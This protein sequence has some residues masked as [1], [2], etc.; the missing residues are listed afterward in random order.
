MHRYDRLI[1]LIGAENHKKLL[2]SSV[3]VV[4]AGGLGSAVLAYLSGS[5][6][7]RIGISDGDLVELHNLDRQFI[8]ANKVG[9]NKA[10]SAKLFVE[11]LNSDVVVEVFGGFEEIPVKKISEYDAVVSCVDSILLRHKINEVCFKTKTPLIHAAISGFEGELAV[12]D[13][14]DKSPCYAC[15][16]PQ[17]EAEENPVIPP[18]AGIVGSMQALE[19]IKLLC[20]FKPL[21]DLLRMDFKNYELVKIKIAKRENCPVCSKTPL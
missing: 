2:S 4:G 7:G 5:G 16:Y 15:I 11:T 19:T 14:R 8:H 21:K 18:V 13:F 10:L 20:G 3:L 1:K 9:M 17:I 12:F 6:V